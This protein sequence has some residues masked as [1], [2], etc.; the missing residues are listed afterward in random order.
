VKKDSCPSTDMVEQKMV[1]ERS[2]LGQC[3]PVLPSTRLV[4]RYTAEERFDLEQGPH[5]STSEFGNFVITLISSGIP[6]Y[7]VAI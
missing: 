1:E 4:E 7:K 6:K 5:V 2:K 3:P